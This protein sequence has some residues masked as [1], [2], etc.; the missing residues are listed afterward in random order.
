MRKEF[1]ELEQHAEESQKDNEDR[2]IEELASHGHHKNLSFFAFTATPK[3]KTL[4]RLGKRQSDGSYQAFHNY[5]MR[6]AIEEKFI[7]DVL[8]HY[9]TYQ[10]YY[11]ISKAGC[12]NPVLDSSKGAKAVARFQSLHPHNISQKTQIIVEHF[13]SITKRKIGGQAKAMLVTSSRLHAVRYLF[14]FKKYIKENGYK[15]INVLVAFS[16]DVDDKGQTWSEEKINKTITGDSIKEHQ[17]K[18]YFNSPD[19]NILIVAEK[20]QT[21]FDEPLLHTMFVDKKLTD[22]KAVQTLSRLN[23]TMKGK[24]D[25]FVLDFVNEAKDIQASFQQFYQTTILAREIEPNELYKLKN[26]LDESRIFRDNEIDSFAGI[27]YSSDE[28]LSDLGRLSSWIKPALDRFNTKESDEKEQIKSVLGNFI[29]MYGFVIQIVRL[30]DKD[31][32]KFYV[33]SLFLNKCL[34]GEFG[35]KVSIDD[36][37]LLAFYKLKKT[38]EGNILLEDADGLVSPPSGGTAAGDK[39]QETLSEIID[40]FNEKFGTNFTETDKILSQIMEDMKADDY[41]VNAAKEGNRQTYEGLFKKVFESAIMDRYAQNDQFFKELFNDEEKLSFI[42]A[43]VFEALYNN[44]K[45]SEFQ[46][47]S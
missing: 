12:E 26:I 15:D 35:V 4:N 19:F 32:Q 21:G 3:P 38:Y 11:Q 28:S 24:T 30:N 43:K 47:S 8:E 5:S 2:L 22:V 6:Q 18:E 29:R 33:Y 7:L 44:L 36:Q 41:I 1:A 27:Y 34:K 37:L 46:L 13:K 25:T 42:R 14:E 39:S 45:N 16:G 31:L 9:V 10:S 40:K 20:Y 17:L 23:R